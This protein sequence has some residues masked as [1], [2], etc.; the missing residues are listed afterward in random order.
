M[1]S[2]YFAN[3]DPLD[4]INPNKDK[5]FFSYF[6]E[7]WNGKP[8]PVWETIVIKLSGWDHMTWL[9]CQ[10]EYWWICNVVM[11][12]SVH[13]PEQQ[14]YWPSLQSLKYL[15]IFY[16]LIFSIGSHFYFRFP[17]TRPIIYAITY[18]LGVITAAV[19]FMI[20]IP[21]SFS[22]HFLSNSS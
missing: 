15:L 10:A 18:W 8:W 13:S 20:S 3:L 7:M 16:F 21:A 14:M 5:E 19:F 1:V 22:K 9:R 4:W 17:V 12:G 2:F 6:Y 11:N